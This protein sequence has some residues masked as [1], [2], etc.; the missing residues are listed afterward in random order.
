MERSDLA[1]P[2]R[3]ATKFDRWLVIILVLTAIVTCIVLPA[4]R[5]LASGSHPGPL[6]PVFIPLVIWLMV[7]PCTLPRYYEVREDC[8]FLRQGWRK[9]LI[10]YAALAELQCVSNYGSAGVF[11]TDRILVVTREGKRFL[12][13]PAEREHFLNEMAQRTPQLERKSF[14]LG[15]P[16]SS[17]TII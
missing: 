3:F 2:L 9:A 10:P 1:P 13:A 7:L 15:L 4:I 12:I 5:F 11:S 6:W 14:G 16:F 8:L 17:P